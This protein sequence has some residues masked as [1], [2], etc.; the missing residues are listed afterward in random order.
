MVKH[1][2]K[3]YGNKGW[4]FNYLLS[5]SYVKIPVSAWCYIPTSL[6]LEPSSIF[7]YLKLN[8]QV[9]DAKRPVASL[10]RYMPSPLIYTYLKLTI[11]CLVFALRVTYSGNGFSEAKLGWYGKIP[12]MQ[13]VFFN[14]NSQTCFGNWFLN[15]RSSYSILILFFF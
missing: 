11:L 13:G 7:H 9:L 3:V 5:E 2:T 4:A 14:S 15:C 8:I 10:L 1:F 12:V 6:P